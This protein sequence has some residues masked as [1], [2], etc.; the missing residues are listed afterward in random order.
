MKKDFNEKCLKCI[1]NCKQNN[2]VKVVNCKL[3]KIVKG[4][5][6]SKPG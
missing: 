4:G 6:D 3:F 2:N 5:V 1:K